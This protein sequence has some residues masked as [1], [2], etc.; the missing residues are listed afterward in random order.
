MAD[1]AREEGTALALDFA[2]LDGVRGCV[3]VAVQDAAT[4]EVVLVAYT[5]E[6]A[7]RE[8]FRTRR[9]VLWST[10]RGEMWEKGATSGARFSLEA[11]YVNCE[12][13]S[14]LYLV[15]PFPPGSR[16]GICHTRNAAGEPRNCF[17]RRIDL[18]TMELRNENP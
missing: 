18:D 5:N 7:M 8:S 16:H 4:R 13:N 14:L 12:Q 6:A 9:L 10:S 3:P 11:A 1:A 2:K 17:Y 15:R